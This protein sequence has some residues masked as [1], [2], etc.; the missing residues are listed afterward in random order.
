MMGLPEKKAQP[1]A[2]PPFLDFKSSQGKEKKVDSGRDFESCSVSSDNDDFEDS[3]GT[4]PLLISLILRPGSLVPIRDPK[5]VWLKARKTIQPGPPLVKISMIHVVDDDDEGDEMDVKW[6]KNHEALHTV[7]PSAVP[8]ALLHCAAHGISPPPQKFILGSGSS[9]LS[10]DPLPLVERVAPTKGQHFPRQ[11]DNDDDMVV[12]PPSTDT[13]AQQGQLV[14][15]QGI[16]QFEQPEQT[17]G[18]APQTVVAPPRGSR[19]IF[20][21]A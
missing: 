21:G 20:R 2:G 5:T 1:A 10:K 9:V 17:P 13:Q 19:T 15:S 4:P 16:A 7:L 12:D 6:G 18:L 8:P 14:P 3:R 11:E